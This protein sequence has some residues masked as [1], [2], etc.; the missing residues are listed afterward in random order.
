MNE[1][2]YDKLFA[3]YY[4]EIDAYR[5]LKT[6][7]MEHKEYTHMVIIPDDLIVHRDG[8]ELLMR[9]LQEFDYPA[10]EGICNVNYGED[11]RFACGPTIN[12]GPT[13]F[14]TKTL[15]LEKEKQG[16]EIIQVGSES[17]CCVFIKR[18][19]IEKYPHAIRGMPNS[20]FDWGFGT[21]CYWE[22]IP[23]RVDTRAKFLHLAGRARGYLE[24]FYRGRKNPRLIFEDGKGTVVATIK[25]E[26]LLIS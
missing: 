19:I 5:E 4:E 7:F 22:H 2:P 6:Y 20:S 18:D 25:Q 11:D 12:G 21:T 23:M 24:H 13:F 15:Q 10:L 1:L 16:S 3:K 9:D 17:F 8:F 14:N 26:Q